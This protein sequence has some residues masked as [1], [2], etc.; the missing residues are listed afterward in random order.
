MFKR[1]HI[2]NP[3]ALGLIL[4]FIGIYLLPLNIRPL[5]IP[6][7]MRY[8]E[9]AREMLDSGDFIVPRLNGLRYFEKP[10]GGHVLNA[11]AMAL[12]GE[13]NFA[14]RL[15]S[16]LAAGFTALSLFWLLRRERGNPTAFLAAFIF[17]TCTEVMGLG[18]FSV[19]DTLFS[20]LIT[21]SLCCYYFTLKTGG[22]RRIG[23]LVLTGFLAGGAFLVKGFIAFAIPVVV[24]VPFLL[25]QRRWKDLF[26][27]SWVPLLS[28]IV[29]VLPWSL[30]IA[31]WEPDFW[32]YFFW[33]EHIRRFF[34]EGRAQH[35]EPFWYFIPILIAG[36]LPW[37]L[38][39]PMPLRGMFRHR[40]REP[41][42][43]FAL[44]WLVM[45][46]LF[47]SSSSGKLAT[48][49]LPCFAPFSL[50]LAIAL[51]DGFESKGERSAPQIG[52]SI[53]G[54]AIVLALLIVLVTGGLVVLHILPPL[55]SRFALKF[56][57]MLGGLILA[58][59]LVIHAFRVNRPLRKL[60]F[61]GVSAATVFVTVTTC[62]PTGLS[63]SIAIQEHLESERHWIEPD[64]LVVG[65][66][67][68][69]QALC[70]V[71]QRDDV[72]LFNGKGELAYG[73]S[74]PEAA[75]RALKTPQLLA[76][77]QAR[78]SRSLVLAIKDSP[79]NSVQSELP[80]PQYQQRWSKIWFAVYEPQRQE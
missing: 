62:L 47:F 22:W 43:Q 37:S 20:S 33:E 48:Y 7:E 56:I 45:T 16:A 68:M 55:D 19:L 74:Y 18:T 21:A 8:G 44:S 10:A 54:A 78:G 27:L 61:L 31:A 36:A 30:A 5:S 67:K 2:S 72:Y 66:P 64:T 1:A 80:L 60:I 70:Y 76:L 17:L 63:I 14:V 26:L 59:L 51:V 11:G 75:P 38:I 25:F 6:D 58:L 3:F 28:A 32:R 49:I 9:I 4:L 77:I 73:L 50:L 65:D 46:F 40:L 35:A 29:F 34:S 12:F 42:I 23:L 71:Y 57:C 52:I 53:L 39:A 79:D 41:L 69:V 13:T 24:I 15:M